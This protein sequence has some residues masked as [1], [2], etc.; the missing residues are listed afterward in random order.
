MEQDKA[1]AASGVLRLCPQTLQQIRVAFWIKDD[2]HL[3]TA[4]VLGGKQF[5]Q[6]FRRHAE[7]LRGAQISLW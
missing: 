7:M 4:D 3:T 6:Q 1:V 2:H 5:R